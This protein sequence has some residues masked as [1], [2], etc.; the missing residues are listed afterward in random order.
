MEECLLEAAGRDLDVAG[1]GIRGKHGANRGIRV[2]A[3]EDDGLAA[4]LDVL[5]A[6]EPA[7]LSRKAF[8]SV[9][10]IVR[11]PTI[12]M[13]TL[14][15]PSATTRPLAIRIARSAYMSASSR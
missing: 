7:E 2:G 9:A 14:V 4:P 1:I 15:G 8:G 5:D 12:A 6:G 11:R 10:R 13:I 3:G